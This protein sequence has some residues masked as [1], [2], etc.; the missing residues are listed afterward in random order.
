[1]KSLIFHSAIDLGKRANPSTIQ[2]RLM[3]YASVRSI[4][5]LNCV[6]I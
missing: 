6:S 5:L 2:K 1:M 4:P 3:A